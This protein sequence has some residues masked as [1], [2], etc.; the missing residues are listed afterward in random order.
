[1]WGATAAV[2]ALALPWLPA[3]ASLGGG[4]P[5]REWTG[6]PCPTCGGTRAI[7]ALARGDLVRA[8]RSNPVVAAGFVGFELVGLAAYPWLRWRGIVP[9]VPVETTRKLGVAALLIVVANWVWLVF[10]GV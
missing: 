3:L 10:S 4:C 9:V 5:L 8:V 2:L 7:A 6:W 1:M